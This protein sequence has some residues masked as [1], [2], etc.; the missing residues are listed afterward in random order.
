[1]PHI[2]YKYWQHQRVTWD[3][4]NCHPS[5]NNVNRSEA[6]LP[7]CAVNNYHIILNVNLWHCLHYIW[8]QNSP[9][10]VNIWVCILY[11]IKSNAHT[12]PVRIFGE[13]YAHKFDLHSWCF[14]NITRSQTIPPIAMFHHVLGFGFMI[15]QLILIFIK[16][17]SANQNSHFTWKYNL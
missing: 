3:T 15:Q 13:S 6:M 12:T 8:F 17:L 14:F 5:K 11:L 4:G 10:Q 7:S 9:G 1:M 16:C 2:L